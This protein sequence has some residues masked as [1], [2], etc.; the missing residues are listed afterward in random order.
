MCAWP[1]STSL[2]SR[3]TALRA[4]TPFPPVT[5]LSLHCHSLALLQDGEG[6]ERHCPLRRR[7]SQGQVC[8]SPFPLPFAAAPLPSTHSHTH[9]TTLA[10]SLLRLPCLLNGGLQRKRQRLVRQAKQQQQ[11]C[12][13]ALP[14]ALHRFTARLHAL[15]YLQHYACIF[16]RLPYFSGACK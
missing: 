13:F 4:F 14:P 2:P 6:N 15:S 11:V 7:K 1:L 9:S 10:S 5:A 3:T 12:P 16:L 8:H